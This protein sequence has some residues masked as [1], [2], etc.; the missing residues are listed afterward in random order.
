MKIRNIYAL[1]GGVLSTRTNI[2]VNAAIVRATDGKKFEALVGG[3]G[4]D[5]FETSTMKPFF[6]IVNKA[7]NGVDPKDSEYVTV[8]YDESKGETDV[9]M[10]GVA[11]TIDMKMETCIVEIDLGFAAADAGEDWGAEFTRDLGLRND[12]K[13]F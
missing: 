13:K 1:F 6:N 11:T 9:K 12:F 2:G 3:E 10:R 4:Q 5:S 8:Y 7:I